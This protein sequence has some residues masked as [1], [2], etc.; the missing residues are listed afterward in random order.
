MA[1]RLRLLP[2]AAALILALLPMGVLAG[3]FNPATDPSR[4]E[5][6]APPGKVGNWVTSAEVQANQRDKQKLADE[7]DLVRAGKFNAARFEQD[8]LAFETKMGGGPRSRTTTAVA[9]GKVAPFYCIP[10]CSPSATDGDIYTTFQGQANNAYCGP[11]SG[12]MILNAMGYPTSV[13]DGA[14]LSQGSLATRT[15]LETDYWGN[16]PWYVSAADQPYPQTLNAWRTG[17]YNGYYGLLG[18]PDVATQKKDMVFDIVY[19]Y[20]VVMNTVEYYTSSYHL[21]GHPTDKAYYDQW[22]PIG[23]WLDNNG[24]HN[25][26]WTVHYADSATTVWAL[27]QPFNDVNLTDINTLLQVHGIVW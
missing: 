9:S 19:G 17:S 21:P 10:S 11:A 26:G 4:L 13:Y 1:N 3:N 16:T 7:F 24:F 15:Y 14:S 18:A 6:G 2:L 8:R 20:P 25:S 12:W 22:G 5:L 23:H 27:V